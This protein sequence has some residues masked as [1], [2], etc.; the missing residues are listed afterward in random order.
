RSFCC[1]FRNWQE[2]PSRLFSLIPVQPSAPT[3]IKEGQRRDGRLPQAGR[4]MSGAP[5]AL[6][7]LIAHL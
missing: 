1:E 6:E 5:S 7:T 4:G 2:L 3:I